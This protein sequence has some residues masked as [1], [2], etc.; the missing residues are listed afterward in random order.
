M[1][2]K[3]IL[4]E[5]LKEFDIIE[6]LKIIEEGLLDMLERTEEKPDFDDSIIELFDN[7][8]EELTYEKEDYIR[9]T[10]LHKLKGE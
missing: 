9:I 1:E 10:I 2:I 8:L 7:I 3:D 4:P 5:R 6:Q